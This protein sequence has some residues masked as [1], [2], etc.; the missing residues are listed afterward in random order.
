MFLK[1]DIYTSSGSL[2]LY[3]CWTDRVTKFDSSSFYNWEQDNMPVYDLDERT[4][5]LWE[6]LGYP[7]SSLPGAALVVSADATN[8]DI[9]CNKNIYR[10]VSAAIAALPQTINFPILIEVA[11]FGSLGDLVLDNIKFGPRGSIEIINRNFARADADLSSTLG[12]YTRLNY[13]TSNTSPN[14]Y[15]Y[16]SAVVVDPAVTAV[17]NAF[18]AKTHFFESS[19]LSISAPVFSSTSD[20]RL[21]NS[22]NGFSQL[23]YFNG[24]FNKSTLILDTQNTVSP[25]SVVNQNTLPFKA[26]DIN[27]DSTDSIPT[28]DVSTVNYITN[29]NLYLYYDNQGTQSH[30][31]IFYGN[32]LNKIVVNNCNGPIFIRNFFL[33]GNGANSTGNNYGVEINNCNNIFLENLVSTRYRK[34]GFLFN[35]SNVTLLRGCV[36]TRN[37][38][39]DSSNNRLTGPWNS[40][41]YYEVFGKSDSAA[42]LLANN[43]IITVSST[44][45]MEDPLKRSKIITDVGLITNASSY[46]NSNYIFEFS[47][48]ANGIILNNSTLIGGDKQNINSTDHYLYSIYINCYN[49]NECGL[50]SYNS[51]ISLDARLSILENLYGMQLD[52]SVF[53]IDKATFVYN[54]K[55]ALNA[56]NSY[57]IYN[58]NLASYVNTGGNAE[59]ITPMYFLQNGQHLVLNNSKMMPVMTSAMDRI[60]DAITFINSFGKKNPVQ[61]SNQALIPSVE[62]KN[63]SETVLISPQLSRDTAHSMTPS[64][65]CKGSELSVTNN[66]KATLQGAKYRATKVIGPNSRDFHKNLAAVY[67]GENSTIELNGPSVIAQYGI[68]LLADKKSTIN[69]N[70]AGSK[71]EGSI[72][73]NSFDLSDKLN[74]TAVE[75]HATRSCVVV[76]DNSTFNARDLGSFKRSWDVTGNYYSNRIY[77]GIDYEFI[78]TIEPYVSAGSLQFYPNPIP[79]HE[80]GYDSVSF[81]GAQSV[82]TTPKLFT[83]NS[84]PGMYFLKDQATTTNFDFSTVTNGGFC[85]R[86]LNNSFVNIH[87]VNFPAGWWNCSAPYY[88]NGVSPLAGGLCYKTF[89]WN[90]ADSSQLKASY[91]SVSGLFPIAAGYIGP[92]GVWTS[93]SNIPASGLP[94]GTP[95]T[96]S[97]SVLD[98]FGAASSNPYGSSAASNYGPFRLYFSVDPATHALYY[99]SSGADDTSIIPQLYSQGYLPSGSMRCDP[100]VSSL[101]V[102]LRQRNSSNAI[103]ASGFYYGSAMTFPGGHVRVM[104]DE[105]AANVFANAKHCAVGKSGN[106]KLVSIYYP[107]YNTPIGDSYNNNIGIKSIN[108]FDLQRDN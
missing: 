9:G 33:N 3:N 38:D 6:Q 67:A 80:G 88:D 57:I 36:A 54:Q 27:P 87:N 8:T 50:K 62:I 49:N 55:T 65:G 16:G 104:L 63:N 73:F 68:D 99:S 83:A 47:K 53:E 91:L 90:I 12:G 41:K 51:K 25:Y 58:K 103:V 44:R 21:I 108:N 81:P 84:N 1:D 22:L 31:A 11:N 77:S 70:P 95:D 34:A 66:S 85:V 5:Y 32:K 93:G 78:S 69:I 43:S 20:A 24:L 64:F 86:A 18:A 40:K 74:H 72:D 13:S 100:S 2:K 101:Y 79:T 102:S 98:Y 105:S 37:Y 4:F 56:N 28:H 30:N 82:V 106:N 59:S 10:T 60:Y 75:L 96:S 7:T 107:Y 94:L 23:K 61:G 29:N 14:P 97:L 46:T 48:N 52:S 76:N 35:N 19:C 92:N 89:I 45:S 26:Y 42:G 39:F 15:Y 71:E 17:T